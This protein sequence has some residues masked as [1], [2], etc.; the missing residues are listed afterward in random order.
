MEVLISSLIISKYE[1]SVVVLELPMLFILIFPFTSNFS[2]GAYVS[3]WYAEVDLR[4]LLLIHTNTA[5]LFSVTA[6]LV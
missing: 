4:G 6:S 2:A 1:F 3:G 5:S